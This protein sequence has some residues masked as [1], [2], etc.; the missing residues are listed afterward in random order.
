MKDYSEKKICDMISSIIANPYT[1]PL[2][3]ENLLSTFLNKRLGQVIV[4][5]CGYKLNTDAY[6]LNE[7]DI[8]GI[9]SAI[10]NF[11][12]CV[13]GVNGFQNAQVTAGGI[14]VDEFDKDS[15]ESKFN[16]HLY[17]IGEILDVTGDCGGFNLQWAFSSATLCAKS[18]SEAIDD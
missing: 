1:Y 10:K 17:A 11:D 5:Y 2:T 13:K 4:K 18:I 9:A 3:L 6:E 12:L 14:K 15:L 7:E 8:E 16:K